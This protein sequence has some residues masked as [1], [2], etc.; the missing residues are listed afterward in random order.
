MGNDRHQ[1]QKLAKFKF[2][3]KEHLFY[4]VHNNFPL[5]EDG[6]IEIPF[7]HSY[8]FSLTKTTLN[9][10]EITHTL[11]HNE[12]LIPKKTMKLDT[13]NVTR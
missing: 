13:L 7:I 1:T 9:L 12:I 11:H 2:Q 3:N 10:V 6:I 5:P 8:D 4:I